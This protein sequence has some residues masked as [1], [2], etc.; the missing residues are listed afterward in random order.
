MSVFDSKKYK[1]KVK[2]KTK[3]DKKMK[4]KVYFLVEELIG[5]GY[6]GVSQETWFDEESADKE[7]KRL[8][9]IEA[10]R[11]K[12]IKIKKKK[13]KKSSF[14]EK[15]VFYLESIEIDLEKIDREL[16]LYKSDNNE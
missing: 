15:Y 9:K 11:I 4:T 13:S 6:R 2:K 14:E 7:L 10:K 1:E 12:E 3:I 5:I 8:K 16:K